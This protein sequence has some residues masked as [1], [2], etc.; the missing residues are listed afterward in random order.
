MKPT[1]ASIACVFVASLQPCLAAVA[2][3]DAPLR[4]VVDGRNFDRAR[5]NTSALVRD[6]VAY[7]DIVRGVRAV[8][9]WLRFGP[10]GAST[11]TVGG[12]SLA[13]QIG[14]K[15]AK[16]ETRS[17]PLPGAPFVLDGDTFVPLVAVATLASAKL[18]VDAH[19]GRA[20]IALGQ[21]DGYAA[22]AGPDSGDVDDI[23]PSPMQALAFT[24]TGSIDATGLHA[25]V[26]IANLTKKPYAIAF[27]SARQIAFIL[28]RNGS[29]V[30]SSVDTISGEEPSKLTIPASGTSV[31]S[32]DWPDVDRL[33]AGRYLLRVRLMTQIPLDI[34]PISLGVVTASTPRT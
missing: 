7:V 33:G 25:R 9:G 12:R 3:E 5:A 20:S 32:S 2:A 21:G 1:A 8:D 26:E 10:G 6:G 29:E 13:F 18:T 31:V 28:W 24:T 27:P 19:D 16:L 11:V 17:V 23:A 4:L 34:T 30:W 14:R 22:P 15:S